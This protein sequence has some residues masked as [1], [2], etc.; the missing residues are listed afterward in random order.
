MLLRTFNPS[1]RNTLFF[2]YKIKQLNVQFIKDM[3]IAQNPARVA[4]FKVFFVSG[5]FILNP[6]LTHHGIHITMHKTS[7]YQQTTRYIFQR[8]RLFHI[9]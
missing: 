7:D 1:V 9:G 6:M 8:K 2:Q 5:E 4:L 3:V